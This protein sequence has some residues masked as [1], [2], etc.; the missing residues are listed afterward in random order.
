LF[1]ASTDFILGVSARAG[2][3]K[4]GKAH[5]KSF[6]SSA[7]ARRAHWSLETFRG[8]VGGD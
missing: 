8:F 3:P 7:S 2:W 6:S 5:E 4:F 1:D